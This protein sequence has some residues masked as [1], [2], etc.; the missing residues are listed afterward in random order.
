MNKHL[1]ILLAVAMIGIFSACEQQGE[2]SQSFDLYDLKVSE[3][4]KIPIDSTTNFQSLYLDYYQDPNTRKKYLAYLS[5][6]DSDIHFYDLESE[7]LAF[8]IET[9]G[10]GPEKV[11]SIDAFLIQN[12]DSVYMVSA[13]SSVASLVNRE[14]KL[15][16]KYSL[17]FSP[18]HVFVLV[19]NYKR[20]AFLTRDKL[21]IHKAPFLYTNQPGIW[22]YH[23]AFAYHTNTDSVRVD[24]IFKYTGLPAQKIHGGGHTL[25]GF[26]PDGNGN[27][28]YS[29]CMDD[30]LYVTNFQGNTQKHQAKSKYVGEIPSMKEGA[31]N[32]EAQV[33]Y[34]TQ[35]AYR[36]IIYDS[37]RKVYYR[38]VLHPTDEA[39]KDFDHAKP[40]SIIILDNNFKKV[41]ETQIFKEKY[42]YT[43]FFVGPKGLYISK[44]HIDNPQA[45]EDYLSFDLFKLLKNE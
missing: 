31:V 13:V 38:F 11:N 4:L 34:M 9:Q 15:L 14:G 25:F 33:F 32:T 3:T 5:V 16:K 19:N 7:R 43:N 20:L 42:A 21:I 41:G 12:L 29:F 26:T 35:Y 36:H 23:I 17:D 2:S 45:D 6:T 22:D 27:Y 28:I 44:N 24:S 40:F 1:L 39:S 10:D 8:K 18:L 30:T 37:F